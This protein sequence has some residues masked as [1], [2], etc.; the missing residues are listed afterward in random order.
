MFLLIAYKPDSEDYCRGCRMA[1]Y[2][3]D[4]E[5]HN[6]LTADKLT[7]LLAGYLFKNLNLDCNET[8]YHFY[9]YKDGIQVWH[10]N[11]CRWDGAERYVYNTDEYWEHFTE[12]EEREKQD[13]DEINGIYIKAQELA[14]LKQENKKNA[15]IAKKNADIAMSVA[16]E[17]ESRRL[18]FE[19]LQK[20]FGQ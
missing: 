20:E 11:Y 5:T 1:S 10:E 15:D 13:A 16:A 17:K 4:F 2:S 12:L 9:I 19:K 18:E 6:M 3:A 7:E 14:G 8:G